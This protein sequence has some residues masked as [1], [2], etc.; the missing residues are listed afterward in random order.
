M[1]Y[2]QKL[3][4]L[5]QSVFQDSSLNVGIGAAP[6]GTYKFEVTGSDILVNGVRIG[7][8]ASSIA[9]NTVIGLSALPVNTTG[10]LN[11]AIGNYAL[12]SNTTGYGNTSVGNTALGYNTT[13]FFN[14]AIGVNTLLSNTTGTYNNA[15]GTAAL[16]N[17][18]TGSYNTAIG[19]VAG[20]NN[21]TGSNNTYIG[22]GS[23]GGITTGSNNTI[24][25]AYY[26]T[27]AM[28]NNIVLAD[29]AGTVR[30]QWDGTN[31]VFGNPLSGTSASFS[32]TA[33]A[34]AFIPTG[35]SVPTN[36][37]YLSAAN[38]LNFATNTTNRLSISS[39]GAATFSS[40]LGCNGAF[41][42]TN[43]WE[44]FP[45]AGASNRA[46]AFNVS[47]IAAGDFTISQGS[48]AT[49][50][51]YTPR[52]VISNAG[53]VG[54]GTSTPDTVLQVLGQVGIGTADGN[55]TQGTLRVGYS[56]GGY[57]GQL[58]LN[59]DNNTGGAYIAWNAGI[60]TSVDT[61]TYAYTGAAT[62]IDGQLG[63]FKFYTAASGTA[64]ANITFT[65][66]MRITSG[67]GLVINE[68]TQQNGGYFLQVGGNNGGCL[69]D[70]KGNGDANY[71]STSTTIG[72]HFYGDQ[73]GG[74]KFYVVGGGQIYSTSTSITGISDIR[75]KENI[76]N[77]ETGLK[78]LLL[79]KPRRFDWKEGK[80]SEKKNVAG[81]IAQE[82]EEVLPDLVDDWKD[83]MDATEYLKAIRM[84]DLIPTVVKAIQEMNTKL[85]EQNKELKSRLDKAG[86]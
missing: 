67:G 14:A 58:Y 5:A 3:G 40:T 9:S 56:T 60:K 68:T 55:Y 73:T 2:T 82:L 38:T 70:A 61:A 26:G 84:S 42:Q 77:L 20:T 43:Q 41:F 8:G 47:N 30:Y 75:H 59:A 51:T 31:N 45:S 19:Q 1:G 27:A 53:N 32:S 81:F 76:V 12:L 24:I 50:G 65:E 85:D 21:T 15:L 86:L 44:I 48:T 57:P 33:T 23:G 25:G 80:G 83:T 71:Y 34:T 69:A 7:K 74:A 18:T 39:T 79:L 10:T 66:R 63:I 28:A 6:S 52:L 13:G 64:G 11:T 78:E 36:G 72:Y 29:G 16:Y 35:S 62:K 17:N 54:I 4:L 46:Y 37:M 49:G 22:N